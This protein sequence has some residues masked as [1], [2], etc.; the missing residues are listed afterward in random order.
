MK[1]QIGKYK[2]KRVLAVVAHP[3]DLEFYAA[4]TISI[5]SRSSRVHLAV[6]TNG[7]NGGSM[8][9]EKLKAL[10][11]REQRKAAKVLG[12]KEVV[13]LN[14][15]DTQVVNVPNLRRRLVEVIIVFKPEML[16]TFDPANEHE[17][18]PDHR[19]LGQA[20]ID[21]LI[22]VDVRG[23]KV[24]EVLLFNTLRPN[25]FVDV[26]SVWNLVMDSNRAHKSQFSEFNGGWEE[27]RRILEEKAAILGSKRGAKYAEAFRR[28]DLSSR[29]YITQANESIREEFD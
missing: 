12:I 24:G 2:N 22:A 14:F 11:R 19:N 10:R 5:L 8:G 28:I 18:H 3:D 9:K 29:T 1:V 26:S 17:L 21:S 4:G 7:E 13:L 20:V 16:I 6:V 27:K 23:W 25:V 15:R